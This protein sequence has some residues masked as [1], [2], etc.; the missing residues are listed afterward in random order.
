[1]PSPASPAAVP[2]V[3]RG[4][5][6]ERG[7]AWLCVFVCVES[8]IT[9]PRFAFVSSVAAAAIRP[10]ARSSPSPPP[11]FCPPPSAPRELAGCLPSPPPCPQPPLLSQPDRFAERTGDA[12]THPDEDHPDV[13]SLSLELLT[14]TAL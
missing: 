12:P 1:M 13:R 14:E 11:R 3:G 6:D 8:P 7:G 2:A 10:S 4:G 5:N 9:S